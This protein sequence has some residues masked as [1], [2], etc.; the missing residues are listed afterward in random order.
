MATPFC[1]G[2]FVS[3]RVE[4]LVHTCPYK[5]QSSETCLAC[6][7]LAELEKEKQ[8][9]KILDYLDTGGRSSDVIV[10]EKP[11][12]DELELCFVFLASNGEL[13]E[14][15]I[16]ELDVSGLV[17]WNYGE[18]VFYPFGEI[19][20]QG[21]AS[22]HG[23]WKLVKNQRWA[24]IASLCTRKFKEETG[25]DYVEISSGSYDSCRLVLY[26]ESSAWIYN[27]LDKQ[28]TE[29][30]YYTLKGYSFLVHRAGLAQTHNV[31]VEVPHSPGVTSVRSRPTIAFVQIH[32][33]AKASWLSLDDFVKVQDERISSE[34]LTRSG[35][36]F[37]FGKARHFGLDSDKAVLGSEET[38]P[39]KW[40]LVEYPR[41]FEIVKLD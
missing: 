22:V 29:V 4:R 35:F 21:R 12:S 32:P 13:L 11:T 38:S 24:L 37:Y 20:E 2:T 25:L 31:Q 28:L 27:P 23:A 9:G 16:P 34:R 30:S 14:I 1:L 8:L 15:E 26:N 40:I 5:G 17:E 6:Q 33:Y 7:R 10:L 18:L 19:L 39:R 41:Y 3:Y 36:Y